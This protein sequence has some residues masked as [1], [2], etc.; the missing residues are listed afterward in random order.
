MSL[1]AAGLLAAVAGCQSPTA[2]TPDPTPL[3]ASG[4]VELITYGGL[5]FEPQSGNTLGGA[6]PDHGGTPIP[7]AR[8]TIVGGAAG[9]VDGGD[10][11]GGPVRVR[12][13]SEV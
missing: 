12:G 7:G 6:F 9:R 2:P 10:G 1:A 8:V 3:E 11:C 13:L 4:P 5:V